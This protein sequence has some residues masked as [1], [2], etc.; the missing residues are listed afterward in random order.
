[1]EWEK[2][3]E[4][5]PTQWY[6]SLALLT[7][8]LPKYEGL[9]VLL[10]DVHVWAPAVSKWME[11]QSWTAESDFPHSFVKRT[12]YI[13]GTCRRLLLAGHNHCDGVVP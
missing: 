11:F 7:K 12:S 4:Q 10:I 6:P 13:D 2:N 3:I 1:M 5:K 9:R 8:H